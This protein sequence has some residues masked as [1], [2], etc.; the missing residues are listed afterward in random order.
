M[1][2]CPAEELEE[3]R[4]GMTAH[5]INRLSLRKQKYENTK[6][7][8]EKKRKNTNE[9]HLYRGGWWFVSLIC[10]FL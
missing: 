4:G 9:K 6:E 7:T 8:K 1:I 5:H 3:D 10:S 2:P